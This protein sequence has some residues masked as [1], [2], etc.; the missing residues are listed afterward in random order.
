[1]ARY[2][3]RI[4]GPL[5]DRID[6]HVDVPRVAVSQLL[7]GEAAEPSSAVRA[8]VQR[9]RDVQRRRH[10]LLGVQTNAELRDDALRRFCLLDDACEELLRA[11]AERLGLSARAVTR[12]T[13]VARTIADLDGTERIA[14]PHLAE[15][16]HYRERRAERGAG[17]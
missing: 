3:R 8:R 10:A 11:A 6:L 15:A 12:I 14:P 13:R 5:L 2:G 16:L 17:A 9:A 7:Q 1:V 4:S